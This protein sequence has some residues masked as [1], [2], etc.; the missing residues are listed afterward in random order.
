M[1]RLLFDE[2]LSEQLCELLADIFPD[3]LHVRLLGDGGAGDAAVW[4]L[5]RTH[6]CLVVSKDEDFNRLAILRGAPPKFVW[7]RRGNCATSEIATLLRQRHDE[8]V[9][10]DKQNEATVLELK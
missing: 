10:F 3:S 5:A 4:D 1:T 9:R 6:N 2:P 7:V 8:I